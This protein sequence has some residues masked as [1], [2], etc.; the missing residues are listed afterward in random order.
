MN[1]TDSF[2]D[3]LRADL[4]SAASTAS[5]D[6]G[7]P[8]DSLLH[9]GRRQRRRHHALWAAAAACVATVAVGVG[10]LGGTDHSADRPGSTSDPVVT[11]VSAFD[12]RVD[13][14]VP[15]NGPAQPS[16]TERIALTREASGTYRVWMGQIGSPRLSSGGGMGGLD[17]ARGQLLTDGDVAVLLAPAS[18]VEAVLWS[19]GDLG[20]V[21]H[22]VADLP[23]V[24]LRAF[25][26]RSDGRSVDTA[27]PL[28]SAWFRADGTPVTGGRDGSVVR[29]SDGQRLWVT[30]DGGHF[31]L[32]DVGGPVA[33]GA[34]A[35]LHEA[36]GGASAVGRP[37]GS[38]TVWTVFAVVRDSAHD[39][40]VDFGGAVVPVTRIESL[41]VPGTG[42]TAIRGV[43]RGQVDSPRLSWTGSDGRRHEFVAGR[44]N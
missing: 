35:P 33:G 18:A 19:V 20:A 38:T 5:T 37:D 11:T 7:V 36:L 6:L 26:F 14:R 22:V 42:W 15:G 23:E 27:A 17:P 30:A 31:G 10:V 1:P 3:L 13:V 44:T 24:A 8:V 25:V 29:F 12:A 41:P 16:L 32:D 39:A 43:V 4:A 40:T 2:E 28:E 21:T 9:D 34:S